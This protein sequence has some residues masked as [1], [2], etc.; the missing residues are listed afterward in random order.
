MRRATGSSWKESSSIEFPDENAEFGLSD[1]KFE[2][3]GAMIL[4]IALII[5]NVVLWYLQYAHYI[6]YF[7]WGGIFVVLELFILEYFSKTWQG[8]RK[9][10]FILLVELSIFFLWSSNAGLLMEAGR[11]KLFGVNAVIFFSYLSY[12]SY[13]KNAKRD[14]KE[15]E[16]L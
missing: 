5:L 4:G 13:L 11:W 7:V 10:W 3:G 12:V 6:S 1:E 9:K 2:N 16:E 14:N 8:K 15:K